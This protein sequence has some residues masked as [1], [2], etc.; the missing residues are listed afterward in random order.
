VVDAAL[1]RGGRSRSSGNRPGVL[2]APSQFTLMPRIGSFAAHQRAPVGHRRTLGLVYDHEPDDVSA[3]GWEDFILQQWESI[4]FGY[5]S[6]AGLRTLGRRWSD[7]IEAGLGCS[8]E[9]ADR[10]VKVAVINGP[11]RMDGAG[12]AAA[13]V[14]GM[15]EML[16]RIHGALDDIADLEPGVTATL[17]K[18]H[19]QLLSFIQAQASGPD[20]R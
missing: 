1:D 17:L 16:A 14:S 5:R 12:D 11:N 6:W 10:L 19:A 13:T 4:F 3:L 9:V 8:P 7:L 15:T 18:Q 2:S 20:S